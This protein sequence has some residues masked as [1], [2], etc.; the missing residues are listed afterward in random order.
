MAPAPMA[1]DFWRRFDD[2]DRDSEVVMLV[3]NGGRWAW[4][5]AYGDGLIRAPP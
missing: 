5:V 1:W 3:T 2:A 4:I